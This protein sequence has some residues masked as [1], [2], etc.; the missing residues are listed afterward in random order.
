LL[1]KLE[2]A[3]KSNESCN[4]DHRVVNNLLERFR[5]CILP[6]RNGSHV[7]E[8]AAGAEGCDSFDA[9]VIKRRWTEKSQDSSW[10]TQLHWVKNDNHL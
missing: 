8:S 10:A 9:A 1:I 3:S 7:W 4:P 5:N 2:I 6:G